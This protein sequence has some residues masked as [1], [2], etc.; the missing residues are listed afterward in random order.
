VK[1]E[2]VVGNERCDKTLLRTSQDLRLRTVQPQS[3][4]A[5]TLLQAPQ[6]APQPQQ[7]P[8]QRAAPPQSGY[9]PDA[10][11]AAEPPAAQPIYIKASSSS[12]TGKKQIQLSPGELLCLTDLAFGEEMGAGG[13]G[14]VYK[15][16][17]RGEQVAIKKMRLQDGHSV[18]QEQL[19][20]F[21]KEV[22]N[23]QGLRHP[24]LIRYIGVAIEIPVI[25]IVTELAPRGSLYQLLYR[26]RERLDVAKRRELC[27]QIVEG[28]AFLHSQKPVRVH[29][30]LKS[31]NVVLDA[32][33]NAKICDFGLTES[34][35]T[36]HISRRDQEGGSPRY[37]APESFDPRKK[38][39]EKID[40][41]AL[42]CL[43]AEILSN[44]VPHS[45]CA[46]VGQVARK[47]LVDHVGPYQDGWANH[48]DPEVLRVVSQ[49][50]A[51]KPEERPSAQGLYEQ[52]NGLDGPL[53]LAAIPEQG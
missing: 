24:R 33:L 32:D 25:C 15:G 37:M 31:Q 28:V 3:Q 18:T 19:D 14:S 43:V 10:P 52:L 53:I 47:L 38:I 36:T 22:A 48:L 34:M 17:L 13:F 44:R 11:Q 30:D 4:Q 51:F 23:L 7:L 8:P 9:V 46:N 49:C 2:F 5:S 35:E 29:R 41:W 26:E 6:P 20:D 16:T 27:L 1:V 12:S 42:G 39:T 21:F 50:F 40:I 45:D